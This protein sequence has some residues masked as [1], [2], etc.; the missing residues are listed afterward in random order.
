ME[1]KT[2]TMLSFQK[3]HRVHRL[4]GDYQIHN[5]TSPKDETYGDQHYATLI[6]GQGQTCIILWEKRAFVTSLKNL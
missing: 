1:S 5:L 4:D 2:Y 6:T 3:V